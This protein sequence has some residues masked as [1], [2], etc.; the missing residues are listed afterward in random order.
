MQSFKKSSLLMF[1][2]KISDLDFQKF[3]RPHF[4]VFQHKW[5]P[6]FFELSD[7][8]L[9]I[10]NHLFELQHWI[11]NTKCFQLFYFLSVHSKFFLDFQFGSLEKNLQDH[12]IIHHCPN[13][14]PWSYLLHLRKLF[15]WTNFHRSRKILKYNYK[16]WSRFHS[17]KRNLL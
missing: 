12:L 15:P 7:Y 10:C 14:Y 5:T 13:F 3:W 8:T 11:L 16:C 1:Q 6:L 4:S 17:S 2:S 9:A